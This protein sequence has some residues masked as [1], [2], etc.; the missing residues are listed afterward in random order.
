MSSM[1][2]RG[3]TPVDPV[4]SIGPAIQRAP[5]AI[6]PPPVHL[7]LQVHTRPPGDVPHG[8]EP[9]RWW[10]LGCHGGAGASTLTRV[11]PGGWDANRMW[12]D[13]RL[14][15]PVGVLLVCR[16]NTAGFTAATNALRQ[17]RAGYTPAHVA[18]WGVVVMADA[19]GRLPKPLLAMKKRLEGTV[20]RLF[21]VPFV[22]AWRTDEPTF[23]NSPAAIAR[24]GVELQS[25]PWLQS[26][27]GK[28]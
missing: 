9:P 6:E 28:R 7:R 4:V 13:P 25:S 19:P 21:T 18:V 2:F 24:I 17:W 1:A 26:H 8:V 11:I 10:W 12:P 3:P 27:G 22:E 5:G 16:S 23:A 15:G 20:Q 14:G